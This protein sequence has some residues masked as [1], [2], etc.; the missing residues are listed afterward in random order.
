VARREVREQRGRVDA[1]RAGQRGDVPAGVDVAAAHRE[2]VALDGLD[3]GAAD[4][5][6][7]GDLLGGEAGVLA[8]AG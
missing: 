3:E 6:A 2:V 5:G 1:D 7:L 4:P 8:R